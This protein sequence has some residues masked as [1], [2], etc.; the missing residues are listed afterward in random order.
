[1]S[2]FADSPYE[3]AYDSVFSQGGALKGAS[4]GRRPWASGT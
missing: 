3:G 2:M 4:L 1:M